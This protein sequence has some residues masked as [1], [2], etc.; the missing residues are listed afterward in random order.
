MAEYKSDFTR[1]LEQLKSERPHI[2]TEQR[3]GRAIWWERDPIDLEQ[4]REWQES[5][6]RQK[7]YP[8]QPG[9]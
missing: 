6:V 5:R 9:D 8:Y 2:D 4:T 1:F 7:P 3:K